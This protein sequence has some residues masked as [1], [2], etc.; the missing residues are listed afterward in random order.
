MKKCP[1]CAE[2]IQDEAIVC[3]HC[4]RVLTS[5]AAIPQAPVKPKKKKV[6]V[7]L[8]VIVGILLLCVCGIVIAIASSGGKKASPTQTRTTGLAGGLTATSVP[9]PTPRPMLGM[10]AGQFVAKYDS[11][12]DLQKKDFIGQSTGKWVDWSGE[13]FDV[14][15]NGTILVNIPETLLSTISLK[16]V[17][18]ETAVSLSKGQTIH[19]TGRLTDVIDFLGLTIYINDV[20]LVP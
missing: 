16:G 2:E 14:Q 15:S 9:T 1:Y 17:P 19:F 10:D 20:Q 11:L 5:T 3:K 8:M 13:I 18:Q 4:G 7:W 12:T 6:P